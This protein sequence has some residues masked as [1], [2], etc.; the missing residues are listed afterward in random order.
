MRKKHPAIAF[1]IF[2]LVI[3]IVNG[4]PLYMKEIPASL[5]KCTVCHIQ[6]SG[7]GGV[8]KFGFDFAKHNFSVAKIEKL[9]SDGDGI[10]NYDELTLG[11]YPGDP[12]SYPSI[13]ENKVSESRFTVK[14]PLVILLLILFIILTFYLK[15][16]M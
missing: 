4:I 5:K 11:T 16:K 15:S 6:S 12:N 10:N 7:I 13:T 2:I 1:L 3:N 8:N 14:L 9:D